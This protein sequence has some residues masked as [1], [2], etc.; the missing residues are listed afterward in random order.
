[1]FM[2]RRRGQRPGKSSEERPPL[3][4]INI[5]RLVGYLRP[6]KGW[7]A[8][9]GLALAVT[10][11][12]SLA[13]PLLIVRLLDSVLKQHS[14]TQLTQLA[15]GLVGLFFV[16]AL[17]NLFQSYSLSYVGERIVINLRTSL[18]AHLQRL[19]LDFFANR[20]VGEIISRIS[21]DVTQVRG[22]LTNNV[23]QFLGAIITLTGSIVIVFILNP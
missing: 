14:E 1:M 8:I 4:A 21:S 20:R 12:V 3:R 7:L 19:S 16:S 2:G 13:F 23:T 9:T 18:Y 5:G 11:A 17:F 6:Y 10:N 22:V 15:L